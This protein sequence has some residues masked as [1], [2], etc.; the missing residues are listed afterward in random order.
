MSAVLEAPGKVP[1]M[2]LLSVEI[3]DSM[4]KNGILNENDNVELLNGAI[5]EK[6]PKG[7]RHTSANTFITRFFYRFL[8]EQAVIRVQDPIRLDEF[9]ELEPDVVLARL[10]IE[11]YSLKHPT[12]EDILLIIEVSDTTLY[13]DRHDKAAAYSRN[14]IEQYLIVNVENNTIE[15]YRKP[16][17]DGYQS[18]QTYEIG[19]KISLIHFPEL[20]IAVEDFLQN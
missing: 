8:G 13:F 9:S 11:R 14:G 15:D 18:K 3:Y 2:R 1:K 20:E 19:D 10:P 7:T 6:M 5:I 17:A 16:G 12:P 4:I